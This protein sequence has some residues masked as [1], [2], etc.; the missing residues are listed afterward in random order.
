[1]IITVETVVTEEVAV[2]ASGVEEGVVED[3][4]SRVP[5]RVSTRTLCDKAG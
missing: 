5:T 2:V 1:M 4:A 3:S